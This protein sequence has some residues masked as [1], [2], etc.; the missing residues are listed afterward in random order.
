MACIRDGLG[1][2]AIMP[3]PSV[4]STA[5]VGSRPQSPVIVWTTGGTR[6][7][8]VRASAPGCKLEPTALAPAR[9]ARS[10]LLP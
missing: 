7:I 1:A 2:C 3:D 8:L 5:T 4:T 6:G 9:R 10:T